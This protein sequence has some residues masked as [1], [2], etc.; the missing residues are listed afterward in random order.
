DTPAKVGREGDYSD[1]VKP[2]QAFMQA[3]P[4]SHWSAALLTNMGFGYYHDG[5]YSRAM[6]AWQEAWN[7]GKDA[8]SF[9]AQR[10]IDRAAGELAKMHSQVGHAKELEAFLNETKTRPIGGP[11]TEAF[12]SA[13]AGLSDFKLSPGTSY[14]CGPHALSNVLRTLKGTEKQ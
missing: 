10:M 4:Q 5:Y 13:R 12:Q 9:Q 2:L 3:H 1:Y 7:K 11:A 8:P 14:L 6:A